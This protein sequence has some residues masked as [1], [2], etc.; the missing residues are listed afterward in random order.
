MTAILEVELSNP[1]IA[2]SLRKA[3]KGLAKGTVTL[4]A[5]EI[6]KGGIRISYHRTP[7]DKNQHGNTA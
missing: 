4:E 7:K 6:T 3:L 2:D 5:I 1:E